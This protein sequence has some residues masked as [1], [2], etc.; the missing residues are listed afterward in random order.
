MSSRSQLAVGTLA[1]TLAVGCGEPEHYDKPLTP[2]RVG[3][4]SQQTPAGGA[5]YSGSIEPNT[6]VDLA[7]KVGGYIQT[8]HQVGGRLVQDG[9]HVAR[10]T[11]LARVRML[12]YDTKVAQAR[13]QLAEAEAGAARAKESFDRASA[14]YAS[15]S[16][17][18]PDFEAAK[19]DYEMVQAKV[20]GAAAIVR[21]AQN[22]A[23]DTALVAPLDAVV[24]KRLIEVGSLVGPG[25]PG[26][27]LADTRRVKVVFGAADRILPSVRVGA[28]Q[29]V[30]TEAVPGRVFQGRITRISPVADPLTRLF[31]V[32]VTIPNS[33]ELLKVGM[34]AALELGG[35]SAEAAPVLAVP[36]S[37]IVRS[38]SDP[39]GYAVFVVEDRDGKTTARARNVVLGKIVGNLIGVDRGV[40]A[41]ERIIITGATL[42]IDGEPVTIVS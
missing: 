4:V 14:L 28:P 22:A 32:E 9:D 36:L 12:D 33:G 38:K 42:V 18:R 5:R 35:T 30:T 15:K 8:I 41:G 16:I 6:R 25:V 17:P 21:E 31:T 19:G 24:L 37:A 34:V 1:C 29:Q 20:A 26:F 27:V 10:G 7:F 23:N 3:V 2:V 13:S 40:N 39:N 11:V